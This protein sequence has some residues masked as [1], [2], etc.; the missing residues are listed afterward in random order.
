MENL[1]VWALDPE[2]FVEETRF[3]IRWHKLARD[4]LRLVEEVDKLEHF[5]LKA[6]IAALL[7][8][9][10]RNQKIDLRVHKNLLV[11]MSHD[12]SLALVDTAAADLVI[13]KDLLPGDMDLVADYDHIQAAVLTSIVAVDLESEDYC[14]E[15]SLSL[16][17]FALAVV[18]VSLP[19]LYFG[20]Y[21]H[22]PHDIH[23]HRNVHTERHHCFAIHLGHFHR[24]AG[25]GK[26]PDTGV[27]FL[28][29]QHHH[30]LH[31]DR[32]YRNRSPQYRLAVEL[33]TTI[34]GVHSTVFEDDHHGEVAERT[35]YLRSYS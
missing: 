21:P 13:R 11:L 19:H 20:S 33:R 34:A 35:P 9:G 22:R 2:G 6:D 17:D 26:S 1:F 7:A 5:S 23:G 12:G 32:L 25:L 29:Q 28:A 15:V 30:I 3:Y 27:N 31:L 18:L 8:N 14:A 4:K 16:L 24:V 10:C